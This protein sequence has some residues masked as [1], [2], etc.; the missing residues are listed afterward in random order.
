MKRKL[1]MSDKRIGAVILAAGKGTRMQSELAKVLH[2]ICGRPMLAYSVELAKEI[3]ADRIVAVIGHQAERVREACPEQSL[4]FVEQQQQLGTGHAVLQ[5]REA[6]ADYD[7]LILILCGD[8]P[9]LKRSTVASLI[10]H[11]E[12]SGA[13]VTVMTVNL[14]N[15]GSYG[16]VVKNAAG[17]VLKIVEAKDA[18]A[19][20]KEIREIN[21]G[22]YCADCY[23]LF[24]AVGRIE[25]NNVQ[26][27]YYL[28]D[29]MEIARRDGH[30]VS[31]FVVGDETEVMGIN[32]PEDLAYACR[33]MEGKE[34]GRAHI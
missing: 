29:I 15:P 8:V 30:K 1:S 33:A 31:A 10:A 11:H 16:R 20:E 3:G 9:L 28:T 17:E 14:D 34:P 21:T 25:N 32:T 27:E 26:K 23:F 7:G 2:P 18:T 12:A 19:G 22:I 6:F 13:V 5:A 4:I 24:S